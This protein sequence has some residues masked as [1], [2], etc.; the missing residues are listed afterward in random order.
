MV[1]EVLSHAWPP[2]AFLHEGGR[3]ALA[4]MSCLSVATIQG[5]APMPLRNYKLEHDLVSLPLPGLLVQ[6]AVLDQELLLHLDVGGC[7]LFVQH[8]VEGCLKCFTWCPQVFGN[9]I[10]DWILLL[11]LFPVSDIGGGQPCWPSLH[12]LFLAIWSQ[13]DPLLST[14]FNG[15][16]SIV[17]CSL[18]SWIQNLVQVLLNFLLREAFVHPTQKVGNSVVLTFLVLQGEVVASEASYPS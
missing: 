11:L 4:L 2:E 12:R 17:E 9:L 10:E 5:S 15:H 3:A 8:L 1:S 6:E 14:L 13:S 7:S 16:D 18:D